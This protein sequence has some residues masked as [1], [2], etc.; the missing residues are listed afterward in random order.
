MM[1]TLYGDTFAAGSVLTYHSTNLSS[2]L[3]ASAQELSSLLVE[4]ICRS[5]ETDFNDIGITAE[6]LGL[7]NF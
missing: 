6:D 7:V 5:I 4:D 2:S 1:G 3:R